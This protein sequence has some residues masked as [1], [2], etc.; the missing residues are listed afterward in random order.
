MCAREEKVDGLWLMDGR[1]DMGYGEED[2]K[3]KEREWRCRQSQQPQPTI[4]NKEKKMDVLGDGAMLS[5]ATVD[6]VQD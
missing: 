3:W 5:P 1:W 6:G 4:S 2:R